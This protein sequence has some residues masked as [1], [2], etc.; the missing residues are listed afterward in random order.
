MKRKFT[1]IELLVVIAIIAILAAMLLPAL[2][3]AKALAQ[4]ISCTGNLKQCAL[5]MIMYSNKNDGYIQLNTHDGNGWAWPWYGATS[6]LEELGCSPYS[7]SAMNLNKRKVTLCPVGVDFDS[8]LQSAAAYGVIF[9]GSSDLDVFA[10]DKAELFFSG[11]YGGSYLKSP[12]VSNP[13]GYILLMDCVYGPNFEDSENP[14]TGNQAYWYW[15]SVPQNSGLLGVHNG[16]GNLAYLDGHVNDS[17]DK[18]QLWEISK[19]HGI[20]I[21]DGYDVLWLDKDEDSN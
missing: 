9:L 4:K 14:T 19:L 18:T 5:A 1:L 20:L 2:G 6:I 17:T 15:R 8:T 21:D 11:P 16:E 12:A 10:S 13:T 7:E 3:K